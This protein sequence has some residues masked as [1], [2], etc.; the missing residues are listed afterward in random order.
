MSQ[1]RQDQIATQVPEW[2]LGLLIAIVIVTIGW[3]FLDS[4]DVGDD[5]VIGDDAG[6]PVEESIAGRRLA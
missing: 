3:F 4:I 6:V 2:L 5:P 1:R